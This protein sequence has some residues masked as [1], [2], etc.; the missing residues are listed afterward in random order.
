MHL[1]FFTSLL[2]ASL[3]SFPA[4]EAGAQAAADTSRIYELEAVSVHGSRVPLSLGT[5]AR[6]VTVMD[7]LAIAALPAQSVNDLL[8]YV[9]GVDVRQRGDMGVQTDIGIRGSTFNQIAV[10]LN[11]I[12][13]GDPQ[14]GHNVIDFPVDIRDIDRIEVLEGPAGRVYG[15]S[16]LVGAINVVTK[17]EDCSGGEVRLEG[18]SFG[19]FNGGARVA[20]S[21]R[22]FR[23][24]LSAS[25][26]RSDGYSRNKAGGL[27]SDYH[28]VKAFYQG[29]WSDAR[30]D[31]N[32]HAGLSDKDFGSNTFYLSKF[33]DQFEK[34]RKLFFAVQAENKGK[35]QCKP[36]LYWNR[37]LD[38][39]ELFRNRPD[40]YPFNFHRTNV[41]GGNLT[42]LLDWKLGKTAAGTEIRHEDIVSTN[43]GEALPEPRPAQGEKGVYKVGLS[44]TNYNLFLEHNVIRRRWTLSAG[45]I[46]TKNT[47]YAEGFHLYPGADASF[48]MSDALKLYAS[49]NSSLRI[50]TFTEL[51]YSVGDHEANKNLKAEKMQAVEGGVKF[52]RPRFR[53]VASIYWHHAS[54]LIDWIKDLNVGP[55]APW[56]S[57]NQTINSLGQELF[58]QSYFPE[59]LGR[60]D[61]FVRNLKLS[62]SHI[63]QNK[64][65]EKGIES[66]YAMQYLRHKLVA[67]TE[68]HLWKS[69][70]L[71]VAARW[72]D[73]EGFYERYEGLK[74]T[75]ELVPYKPYT[76]LDASLSWDTPSWR[77]YLSFNNLLN[78]MYY[79]YG[80]IPQPGLWIRG[81]AIVRLH[82]RP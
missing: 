77:A 60:K 38:R 32:W 10:L 6:I 43:L 49:Y 47:G 57:V 65:A 76:L 29:G 13:I 24:Q 22:H 75:G 2:A 28:A 55:E 66:K 48:G 35:L 45:V 69:L 68:L 67:E 62:Y 1:N 25:Y 12:N 46:A 44:R 81:G 20:A 71:G 7:S 4:T 79:D 56:K 58:L 3:M 33:D 34:T 41:F 73:R 19:Y 15:S 61:F 72:Q 31:V 39:F 64:Q 82:F 8:K 74:A 40:K 37:S 17:S 70:S 42:F 23:N 52:L 63:S 50:P 9:A 80:N 51:Y 18:G 11:G 5:S 21:G 54:N 59:L 53:A 27:N 78:K 36:S 30:M 26:I 14:T 16:S